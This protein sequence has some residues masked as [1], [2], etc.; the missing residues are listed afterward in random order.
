[1]RPLLDAFF[2]KLQAFTR[3]DI[4]YLLKGGSW[5]MLN[6]GIQI[7]SGILT[8]VALANFLPK[9][10]YGT[11]QF[12]IA[13]ASII[14]VF[15]LSGLGPAVTRAVAQGNDGVLRHGVR[16]KFRWSFGILLVAG[17]TAS[18]YAVRG[19]QT[20]AIAFLIVGACAPFIES[21]NLYE[22]F[23]HG[24]KSF[25]DSVILGAWRKPLP[26][27]AVI[28]AAYFT[29]DIL[30]ILA[31]YFVSN[32]VSMVAVYYS[33][34]KKYQPP[35]NSDLGT[36]Q[37]G[38]HLST[39]VIV[40]RIAEHADKLLLWHF[41]GPVA[42]ATF[43][44]A[45]F[46]ARYSSGLLNTLSALVIPKAATQDLETLQKTL[47]RK[48]LLLMFA[49][50]AGALVY[51][52]FIPLVFPILFPEYVKAIALA[53]FL[54]LTFLFAPSTIYGKALIAHKKITS[55]YII[56]LVSVVSRIFLLLMLIPLYD[57][58]GAAYALILSQALIM[59]LAYFLFKKASPEGT[60]G[61]LKG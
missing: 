11:Y 35:N 19:D 10:I 46:A 38:T 34:T 61:T 9:D 31:A 14:S 8:T 47:P 17:A 30:I 33:V 23:L 5:L 21:F 29:N 25:K 28:T 13:V 44:I 22:N 6:Y 3:T 60:P 37:L 2:Q 20:L 45:Q 12:V 49:M 57:I 7:G 58:W 52:L 36:T 59:V 56:N 15:T 42:V 54:G 4:S 32:A 26:L 50:A 39:L 53:Q 1:M 41:L 51:V 24:K 27:I 16:L 40:G 48:V 18:Y 43:T 55:Q